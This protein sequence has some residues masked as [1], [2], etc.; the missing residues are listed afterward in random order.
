MSWT[1][2]CSF[3]VPLAHQP[4]HSSF[5]FTSRFPLIKLSVAIIHSTFY[6]PL[7]SFFSQWIFPTNLC[8]PSPLKSC[9]ILSWP[10]TVKP[11]S[12]KP[13]W[14]GCP[15]TATSV[16]LRDDT[17]RLA[18]WHPTMHCVGRL[19]FGAKSMTFLTRCRHRRIGAIATRV[20]L[21]ATLKNSWRKWNEW[22]INHNP[23]ASSVPCCFGEERPTEVCIVVYASSVLT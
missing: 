23:N 22:N 2:D 13:S 11:M 3:A 18:T 15:S 14:S 21:C 5:T 7:F 6:L 16:P 8:V 20:C 1:V 10:A 12:G 17:C 19:P 4:S 9:S